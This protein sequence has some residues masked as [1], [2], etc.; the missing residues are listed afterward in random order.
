ME[1]IILLLLNFRGCM[2]FHESGVVDFMSLII[3]LIII[4]NFSQIKI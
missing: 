3:V 2:Q 4:S 1:K